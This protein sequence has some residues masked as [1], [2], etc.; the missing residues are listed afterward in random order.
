MRLETMSVPHGKQ[1]ISDER[2]DEGI[3]LCVEIPG[4]GEKDLIP[5]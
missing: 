2:L 4:T 3:K 5:A 1:A